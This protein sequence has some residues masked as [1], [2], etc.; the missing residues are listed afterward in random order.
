[1]EIRFG[2]DAKDKLVLRREESSLPPLPSPVR[3]GKISG[4]DGFT[5]VHRDTTIL[6]QGKVFHI[7]SPNNPPR[8]IKFPISIYLRIDPP[9]EFHLAKRLNGFAPFPGE[10][11]LEII[12]KMG[13]ETIEVLERRRR[14]R[15]LSRGSRREPILTKTLEWEHLLMVEPLRLE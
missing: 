2:C 7:R 15:P 10:V 4:G 8:R 6:F 3:W 14:R 9:R 5:R 12:E 13:K 1:M 11:L